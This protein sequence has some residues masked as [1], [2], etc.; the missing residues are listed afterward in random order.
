[1]KSPRFYFTLILLILASATSFAY[2]HDSPFARLSISHSLHLEFDKASVYINLMKTREPENSFRLLAESYRD[3]ISVNVSDDYRKYLDVK[4]AVEARIK[5]A[6]K[7]KDDNQYYKWILGDLY[8]HQGIMRLKFGEYLSGARS[9]KK[10]LDL[11]SDNKEEY[12]AFIYSRKYLGMMHAAI[13]SI[14]PEYQWI[15]SLLGIRGSLEQGQAEMN[16]V[17]RLN[18][19]TDPFVTES[20]MLQLF[21]LMTFDNF[22][23]KEAEVQQLIGMLDETKPLEAFFICSSDL[24]RNKNEEAL[25]VLQNVDRSRFPYLHFMNGV[26][27]MNRLETKGAKDELEMFLKVGRGQNYIKSAYLKLAWTDLI[28]GNHSMY[29]KYMDEILKKG[30]SGTDE[31]KLAMKEAE[32]RKIPNI[33]L[34]KARLLFDGGYY[35]RAEKI[36]VT[37]GKSVTSSGDKI[38]Y[39]YRL[40]RIKHKESKTIE[41]IDYYSKVIAA[42][43]GYN[44][45]FAA[46]SALQLGLIY[47]ELGERKKALNYFEECLD[48]DPPQYRASLHQKAKAG[49]HRVSR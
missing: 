40:G 20:K 16:T 11:L 27:F 5:L 49:K 39:D 31:D 14:P 15:A 8:F 17:I 3:F 18:M 2:I 26:A 9:V 42:D 24:K 7:E 45:W 13:S 41:A 46:S 32:N 36:L 37:N 29:D 33:P 21:A 28:A 34:L 38:E 35:E 43:P 30:S 25:A 4:D 1:M 19:P 48:M 12:P 23:K 44:T 47:E 22:E 6:E 10:S